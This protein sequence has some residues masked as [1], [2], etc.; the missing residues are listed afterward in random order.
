M[1]SSLRALLT[2]AILLACPAVRSQPLPGSMDVH[3]N[4][5]AQ[6]CSTNKQPPLQVH[7]YNARTF[8]LR[9]NPCTTFE[10]PFMYLLLGTS[11][12]LLIDTGDVA[13]AKLMPLAATVAELLPQVGSAK[14]PL[15]VVH[16][17]GHLDHR[18]GDAQFALVPH[19]RIEGT[20]LDA[21][22]KF[23]G[24]PDWPNATAQI[25]LGDR[26]VDVIPT[27]GHHAAHVS[28]YDR[29]AAL[30]FSGD[31]FMPG[32]LMIA[33]TAADLA[34]AQRVADFI[35]DRPLNHVLGGHIELD[36]DGNTFDLGASYHP[37]ERALQLTKQALLDLPATVG[38]FNGFYGRHGAFV[39]MNQNRVLMAW[40]AVAIGVLVVLIAVLVRHLRRRRAR[41]HAA[42]S[43]R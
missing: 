12:A 1:Q 5:G 39:M 14:M 4:E 13:D 42:G 15:I 26:I 18:A 33:D 40:A 11:K 43:A 23:F 9:E 27:P 31:F 22:R 20:D 2:L 16:T 37:R 36:A 7:G 10:A 35:R 28:Y 24:L 25:D 19:V 29:E 17:H 8:I 30:F 32:R 34:S 3:W 6:D 41:R 38:S 21:V